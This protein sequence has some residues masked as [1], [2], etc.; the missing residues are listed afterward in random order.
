MKLGL[1]VF[2]EKY[3][4]DYSTE[5]IGLLTNLTGVNHQL[6][7]TIDLF[8]SHQHLNLTALFGPEHG[9]RGEVQ[10]GKLIDSSVDPYTGVPIHSLYNKDKKPN[11]EMLK[12]VDVVFCDLQDIGTRYY[13]FIYSMANTMQICGQE[14]KKVVVLDRPNPINGID[15][16]GN[17]V[18]D[19]FRSF[20]GKFPIPVRHGMTIGELARLFK[21]EFNIACDLEV[22]PME[23][24]NRE[25]Y[26]DQTDLYWVSPTPNTTTIDMCMLYPGTCLI[27]GTNISEGR[28]TT[29]PFEVIGAPFI[30]GRKLAEALKSLSLPGVQFRPAVFKPM[31]QKFAGEVCEGIQVHISNKDT[32]SAFDIGI[33]ILETIY[34]LYPEQMTFIQAGEQ[35]RYFI[36]LLAGT[37]QLRKQIIQGDT[38]DFREQLPTAVQQFMAM[39]ENY[40]LYPTND[41]A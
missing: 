2:L 7:S 24:W 38:T 35:N 26:F 11:V 20:V 40:L 18:Q 19:A 5:R 21:H 36:D 14:E 39:R 8:Y 30:D 41:M 17:L 37:D 33:S 12:D 10:E 4:K 13:T 32:L 9:L 22:I 3:T 31:Y 28:G 16:E 29:K 15:V 1:E 25:Q 27:E 6:E 23:G 34:R